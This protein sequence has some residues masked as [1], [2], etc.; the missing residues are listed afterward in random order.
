MRRSA[1]GGIQTTDFGGSDGAG[2]VALQPDGKIVAVGQAVAAGGAAGDFALARYEGGSVS[3]TAPVNATPPTI[4]GT[5]TEGQALTVGPGTWTGSAPITRDYRWRRC[6]AT[7]ANCVDGAA[8]ASMYT[9]VA[10]DVGHTIRVR[11]TATNAYGQTAITSAATAVVTAKPKPTPGTIT[12]TVRNAKTGTVIAKA[13]VSCGSGY[14]AKTTSGGN[15]SIANVPPGGYACTASA[16]GYRSSTQ[17]VTVSAGQTAT[18]NFS[19]ARP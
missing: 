4:S 2:G 5:A 11:E 19:L 15:Y 17:T 7:G 6:D 10:A 9:L 18:A 14:S 13:G 16:S 12:G 3:G 8:T 1:A